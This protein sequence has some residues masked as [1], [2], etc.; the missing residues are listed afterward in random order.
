MER[1]LG[2]MEMSERD[3]LI[4]ENQRLVT[5]VLHKH[6]PSWAFDEDMQQIGMIGLCNAADRYDPEKGKFSTLAIKFILNEI[7]NEFRRRMTQSRTGDELSINEIS[8]ED[9]TYED[10]IP[11]LPDVD[12]CDTDGMFKEL[13]PNERKVCDLLIQGF[14]Q[15]E[16]ARTLGCSTQNISKLARSTKLKLRKF[17]EN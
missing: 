12:Y 10:C 2:F 17:Y 14:S 4:V 11:G 9:I 15:S 1:R 7:R 5:Y 8:G 16:I 13:K 3:K 6:Y